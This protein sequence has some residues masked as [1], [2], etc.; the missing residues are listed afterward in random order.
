M[1]PRPWIKP[2]F[3]VLVAAQALFVILE[4]TGVG[5][6][7][8]ARILAGVRVAMAVLILIIL[9]YWTIQERRSHRGTDI[10]GSS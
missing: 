4:R 3:F 6:P 7:I 10:E 9:A 5:L 8:P 1:T 2:A